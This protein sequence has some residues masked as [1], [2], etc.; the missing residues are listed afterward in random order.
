[1][2]CRR[3]PNKFQIEFSFVSAP[4]FRIHLLRASLPHCRCFASFLP[5][6]SCLGTIYFCSFITGSNLKTVAYG[7]ICGSKSYTYLF[8]SLPASC[9]VSATEEIQQ[10]FFYGSHHRGVYSRRLLRAMGRVYGL[11]VSDFFCWLQKINERG[12]KKR[13]VFVNG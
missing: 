9:I 11:V 6:E 13:W 5:E 8:S 12:W 7:G 1:M 10:V 3:F 2:R 4:N